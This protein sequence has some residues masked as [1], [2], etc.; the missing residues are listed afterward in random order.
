M[1]RAD[2]AQLIAYICLF[3]GRM[4]PDK[5]RI[6]AWAES[7]NSEIPFEFAKS[8]VSSHYGEKDSLV[9]PSHIN[10][11]WHRR[12]KTENDKKLTRDY[13]LEIEAKKQEALDPEEVSTMVE[14]IKSIISNQTKGGTNEPKTQ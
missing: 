8:A 13:M 7:L 5:G 2:V 14:K 4:V 12:V 10:S 6:L 3:D 9:A 1:E 11:A